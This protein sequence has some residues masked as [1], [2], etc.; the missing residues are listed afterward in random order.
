MIGNSISQSTS[1]KL[2]KPESG[3]QYCAEW[4]AL[5]S[6]TRPNGQE[7][8]TTDLRR[9]MYTSSTRRSAKSHW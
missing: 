5:Y 4:F 8:R 7:S 9:I 1:M 2:D 3:M 6:V